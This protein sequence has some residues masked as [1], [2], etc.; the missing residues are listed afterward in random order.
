VYDAATLSGAGAETATGTVKYDVYSDS[1]CEHLVAEAGE[2]TVS[3][4]SIPDSGE[5]ALEP[6]T[7][8]WQAS[9][10]GDEHHPSA[11][12]TCGTE[13]EKVNEPLTTSLSGEG[14]S[15][16]EIELLD[17]GG[18]RDAATLN[19]AAA[20]TASGTVKYDVYS[21]K[22][23]KHLV[24][25][26]GEVTM[27]G[28]SIPESNEET[29]EPGTYYWQ[30]SYSGDEHHHSA[31]ST[32]GSEIETVEEPVT[33]VLVSEGHTGKEIEV[34]E[35]SIAAHDT[36]TLHGPES[37]TATGTVKYK[38]YS[39]SEC[40]HLVL[41]AGEVTVTGG[42]IPES[43]EE[44]L[45]PG[46]YYWR[47][48]YSGDEH[49]LAA[50]S[51]CGAEVEKVA[52]PWIVSVG[53]SFASGEAGRWAGNTENNSESAKVDALGSEAYFG[54]PNEE[55]G[56]EAIPGCHRSKSAEIFIRGAVKSKNL[57][58]SGARTYSWFKT[59]TKHFKPGI[60]FENKAFGEPLEKGGDCPIAQCEGQALQLEQFAKK[61]E[62]KMI[63][64]SIGGN[65]FGFA[66]IG[67]AC[68]SDWLL[69][70][71]K[72][73]SLI[74][75]V[76]TGLV[77]L[78]NAIPA[79]WG[80]GWLKERAVEFA[81]QVAAT[82]RARLSV[83]PFTPAFCSTEAR[84]TKTIDEEKAWQE[85]PLVE[86]E[87]IREEERAN[88][89]RAKEGVIELAIEEALKHIGEAMTK[90]GY[91]PNKYTIL[92]QNYPSPTPEAVPGVGPPPA[93]GFRYSQEIF[94]RQTVGGCGAAHDER[95]RA[96]SLGS[97]Q[98]RTPDQAPGSV[99]SLHRTAAVR[100]QRR[101]ARRSRAG[102]VEQKNRGRSS[103]QSR[104]SRSGGKNR[105]DQSS[106]SRTG[107]TGGRRVPLEPGSRRAQL[108]P[109]ADQ[110]SPGLRRTRAAARGLG[111]R[112]H[113]ADTS[114]NRSRHRRHRNRQELGRSPENKLRRL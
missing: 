25:E 106:P 66:P 98:R 67:A 21:D 78:A 110:G 9:Y 39:D 88:P 31:T 16:A 20:A 91:A 42:S 87:K 104:R 73:E 17:G 59:T 8:Y 64:L 45:E 11:T 108:D 79:P 58:C 75:V 5:E 47:A 28:G 36:A 89:A 84:A 100:E 82:I 49:H 61:H 10:S 6:G 70:T 85:K 80:F 74:T 111:E 12:S 76:N 86:K 53:D 52:Q 22:E 7:Y 27:L 105:V 96:G 81:E 99:R 41:E 13:I 48:S 35:E 32:C 114:R 46:T 37:S 63:A 71:K 50:T 3:G 95:N 38:V 55:P 107:T 15:G 23:C 44:K 4:G 29:L 57:A 51:A 65:N 18:A 19:G 60:D 34:K 93:E 103:K 69:S 56:K 101:G 24:A 113:R 83:W 92:Q 72:I 97:R 1:K 33:T 43:S 26:A 102:D 94:G 77:E 40:K 62:V 90:A 30:A 14:R 2:V 112:T 54:E 68:V 109:G